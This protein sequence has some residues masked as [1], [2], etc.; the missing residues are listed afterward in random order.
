MTAEELADLTMDWLWEENRQLKA[1][2]DRY[3][4][5]YEILLQHLGPSAEALEKNG[6]GYETVVT[7]VQ[8]A[9]KAVK[10]A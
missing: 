5:G 10:G 1:E 9:K 8:R 2:R 3:R 7:V 6:R 4:A